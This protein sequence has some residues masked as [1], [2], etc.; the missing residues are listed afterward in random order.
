MWVCTGVVIGTAPEGDSGGLQ[1]AVML[2]TMAFHITP[3]SVASIADV[4]RAREQLGGGG[5]RK[6]QGDGSG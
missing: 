2:L 6:I 5:A 4:R 1:V 3:L